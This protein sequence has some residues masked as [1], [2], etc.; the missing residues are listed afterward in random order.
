[1][2]QKVVY[3]KFKSF[4]LTFIATAYPFLRESTVKNVKKSYLEN[5]HQ[6]LNVIIIAGKYLMI[7]FQMNFEG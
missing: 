2:V 6:K 5:L 3:G 7:R 1:M 4:E